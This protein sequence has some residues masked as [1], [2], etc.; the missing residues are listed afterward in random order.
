M[1]MKCEIKA[2]QWQWDKHKEKLQSVK[3]WGWTATKS[4]QQE[5]Q[6]T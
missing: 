5:G 6:Q 4:Q 1:T 2:I 3:T